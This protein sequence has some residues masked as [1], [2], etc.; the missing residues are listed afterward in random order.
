MGGQGIQM[1]QLMQLSC[2]D[3]HPLLLRQRS[4]VKKKISSQT[5]GQYV[6]SSPIWD[7]Y[8]DSGRWL[9]MHDEKKYVNISGVNIWSWKSLSTVLLLDTEL[10]CNVFILGCAVNLLNSTVLLWN[11]LHLLLVY[12]QLLLQLKKKCCY[13]DIP[14]WSFILICNAQRVHKF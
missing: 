6:Q 10:R 13:H 2:F 4:A 5:H 14:C 12:L 11:K 7:T 9:E 8:A 1:I 3:P